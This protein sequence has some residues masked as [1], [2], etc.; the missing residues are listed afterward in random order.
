MKD[1]AK[2]NTIRFVYEQEKIDRLQ[3]KYRFIVNKERALFIAEKMRVDFVYNTT[4]L[5]GNPYT[6]LEIKTLIEGITV[7][8]IKFQILNKY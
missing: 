3:D 7:G 5:E 4:A 1:T 8:G 6:Y 2:K